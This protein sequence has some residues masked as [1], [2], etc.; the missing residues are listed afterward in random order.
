M[1]AMM[2]DPTAGEA[3]AVGHELASVLP[4]DGTPWW[5]KGH[6]VKLNFCIVSLML[7]TS[8][9]GVSQYSLLTLLVLSC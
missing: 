7:F 5:K 4:D 3:K 2:K 6:L 1:G 9:N 8:S